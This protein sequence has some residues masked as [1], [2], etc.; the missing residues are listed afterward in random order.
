MADTKLVLFQIQTPNIYNFRT[1]EKATGEEASYIRD[2][3]QDN[4]K[5]ASSMA[6]VSGNKW[7]GSDG[8]PVVWK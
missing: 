1:F 2:T 6:K 8:M 3:I 4:L 7:E 5:P